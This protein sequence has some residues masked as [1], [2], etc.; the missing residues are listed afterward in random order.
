MRINGAAYVVDISRQAPAG[1]SAAAEAN[2]STASQ[3]AAAVD[4][5]RSGASRGRSIDRVEISPD[6]TELEKL[7]RDLAALPELRL[8]RVALAKQSLQEG[9][10]RL[11][12][13]V[14]A[15]KMLEAFATH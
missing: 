5:R 2:E 8:D 9:G 3:G 14:L 13:R 4:G 12:P 1:E 15:Q 7:K 11:A 10:Y 6:H